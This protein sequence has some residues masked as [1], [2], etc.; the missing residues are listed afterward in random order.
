MIQKGRIEPV[1]IEYNFEFY[2]SDLRYKS[3][4]LFVLNFNTTSD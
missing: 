4:L 3:L 1:G 2:K